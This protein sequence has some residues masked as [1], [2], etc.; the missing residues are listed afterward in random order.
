MFSYKVCGV[1]GFPENCHNFRHSFSNE[2]DINVDEKNILSF[3]IGYCSKKEGSKCSELQCGSPKSLHETD[4]V[5]HKFNPKIFND[6]QITIPQEM[7]CGKEGCDLRLNQHKTEMT[8]RFLVNIRITGLEKDDVV[9]V[10]N[11]KEL[12]MNIDVKRIEY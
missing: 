10:T 1:C 6:I 4:M 8:H 5:T 2:Y 7:K 9:K 12:K 3:D 11:P